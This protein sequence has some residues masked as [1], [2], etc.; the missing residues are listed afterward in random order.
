M[1]GFVYTT[2]QEIKEYYFFYIGWESIVIWDTAIYAIMFASLFY[3]VYQICR[4]SPIEIIK[5]L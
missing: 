5:D 2:P 1:N 4:K 3:M